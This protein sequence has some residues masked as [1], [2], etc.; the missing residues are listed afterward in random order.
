MKW[1]N[2]FG[3]AMIIAA[4]LLLQWP[5]IKKASMKDKTVFLI[6]LLFGWGL[7][8]LDLPNIEGPMTLMR[9]HFKPFAP[10]MG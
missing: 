2:F 3:T 5:R 7:S 4:I 6:L 9:F 10:L 1:G 8:L